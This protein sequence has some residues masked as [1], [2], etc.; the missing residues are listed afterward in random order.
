MLLIA[1]SSVPYVIH[2]MSALPD[3]ARA[4]GSALDTFR[5]IDRVPLLDPKDGTGIRDRAIRGDISIENLTYAACS[6]LG[7]LPL[8]GPGL[9]TPLDL[10]CRF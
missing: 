5:I 1:I 2:S 6:A 9:S 4:S 7:R 8:V 10:A 3:L